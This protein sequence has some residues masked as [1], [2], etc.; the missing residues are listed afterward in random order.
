MN[1]VSIAVR[2]DTSA[3]QQALGGL[4]KQF[5]DAGNKAGAA[6]VAAITSQFRQLHLDRLQLSIDTAS[7]TAQI[8]KLQDQSAGL[9]LNIKAGIDVTAAKA[10]L[11]QVTTQLQKLQKQKLEIRIDSTAAA[12]GMAELRQQAAQTADA[13]EGQLGQAMGGV[14]GQGERLNQV[15]AQNESTLTRLGQAANKAGTQVYF[16]SFG[17]SALA[18]VSPVFETLGLA[19]SNMSGIVSLAGPILESFG[20]RSTAMGAAVA[21]SATEVVAADAE[22]VAANEAVAASSEATSA[23]SAGAAA[24]LGPIGVLAGG[25]AL[26]IG[27]LTAV[28]SDNSKASDANAAAV[29]NYATA[30]ENSKGAI[31]DNVKATIAKKIADSGAIELGKQFGLTATDITQAMLGVAPAVDKV[32]GALGNY[33][34]QQK[35]SSTVNG[36]M[37]I[38]AYKLKD[39]LNQ[40][41]GSFTDAKDKAAIYQS[42]LASLGPTTAAIAAATGGLTF[43][44]LDATAAVQSLTA[45]MATET[46]QAVGGLVQQSNAAVGATLSQDQLNDSFANFNQ[47]LGSGGGGGGGTKKAV[48]D[49]IDVLGDYNLEL[50]KLSNNNIDATEAQD[51]FNLSLL[52]L[53]TNLASATPLKDQTGA[54]LLN[55]RGAINN[56][57]AVLDQIKAINGIASAQ[58]KAGSSASDVTKSMQANE[59]ALVKNATAAGLARRE[60]EALIKQYAI[61]PAALTPAVKHKEAQDAAAAAAKAAA[62]AENTYGGAVGNTTI[63]LNAGRDAVLQRITDINNVAKAETDAGTPIDQVTKHLKDNETALFTY[64]QKLGLTKDQIQKLLDKYGLFPKAITTAVNADTDETRNKLAVILAE[65]HSIAGTATA[66]EISIANQAESHLKGD[67]AHGGIVA[68]ATGGN[69]SGFVRINDGSGPEVVH[70]PNGSNVMTAEDSQAKFGGGGASSAMV[71]FDWGSATGSIDSVLLDWLR[72]AVRVRGGNVQNVLGYGSS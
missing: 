24:S 25:A 12:Q 42:V 9:K 33:L 14:V 68:A 49:V 65:Q 71:S 28:M 3:T 45:A 51:Q 13:L 30:L 44:Y 22:I 31:D 8:A 67:Y 53:K 58:L 16:M 34:T 60:V 41:D 32:Q 4:S 52:D 15:G 64:G 35:N 2:T 21:A 7:V 70:L 72:S 10:E 62:E 59:D 47:V 66:R 27:L 38:D 63:K 56:R 61:K 36:R 55:T 69:R 43:S 48:K 1:E 40:Q 5:T 50:D 46:G 54:V 6:G 18:P 29:N 57:D 37:V 26:G 17:F 20:N 23:A 19:V 39:I 11:D